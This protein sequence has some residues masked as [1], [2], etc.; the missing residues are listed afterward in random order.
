MPLRVDEDI[1]AAEVRGDLLG[2]VFDGC[3]V[4]QVEA[5]DA[6]LATGLLDLRCGLPG[7][8][9]VAV[10]PHRDMGPFGAEDDR[11]C[12]SDVARRA[13]NARRGTRSRSC[14]RYATLLLST[15]PTRVG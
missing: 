4:C 6:R 13:W 12:A 14:A 8:R 15:W 2:G 10:I 7:A 1:H 9:L 5:D 11:C 3:L